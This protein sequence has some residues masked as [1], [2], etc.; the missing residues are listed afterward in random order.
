MIRQV[1]VSERRLLWTFDGSRP[2]DDR[3]W[4]ALHERTRDVGPDV[5]MVVL[6]GGATFGVGTDLAWFARTLR[7][8]Q[9]RGDPSP[10]VVAGSTGRAAVAALRALPCTTVALCSGEVT[11]ASAELALAV[12]LRVCVGECVVR[13]PEASALGL[14]P[15]YVSLRR[16]DAVLGRRAAVRCL[17]LGEPLHVGPEDRTFADLWSTDRTTALELLADADRAAAHGPVL[18][19]LRQVLDGDLP[20]SADH[21][22]A[23]NEELT[24]PT[25]IVDAVLRMADRGGSA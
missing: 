2:V 12:D 8:A 1:E 20:S 11:G 22:A 19:A 6:D 25:D 7:R 14:L 17:V 3:F 23:L 15:D 16:V 5:R 4:A 10:L 24:T 13:L 18:P 9:R 21:C